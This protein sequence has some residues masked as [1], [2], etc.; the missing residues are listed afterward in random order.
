MNERN[1][2]RKQRVLAWAAAMGLGKNETPASDQA[3]E[4]I[5]SLDGLEVSDSSF[6]EWAAVCTSRAATPAAYVVHQHPKAQE[7]AGAL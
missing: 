7:K 3:S 2:S 6:D 4:P 5:A 1:G